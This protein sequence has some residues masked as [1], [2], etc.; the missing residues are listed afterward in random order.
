[1]SPI[2]TEEPE[3]KTPPTAPEIPVELWPQS[4]KESCLATV[5]DSLVVQP[6]NAI[7]QPVRPPSSIDSEHDS[8]QDDDEQRYDEEENLSEWGIMCQRD[9]RPTPQGESSNRELGYMGEQNDLVIS[10]RTEETRYDQIMTGWDP[11]PPLAGTKRSRSPEQEII[12]S[13]RGRP[14]KKVDYKKLHHGKTVKIN[15]DPK[16]WTEAMEGSEAK[17]WHVAAQEEFNSLKETGAIKI[18]D[19]TELP[20]GR[21]LMKSKWVFKKK[22]Q[23]DG[24]LDKY[25]AR[26]TVKGYTQRPGI[27]YKETFAPTPRPETGRI[28]LAL[29]HKLNWYR[30]QG[31]VPV[32]FLNPDLDIDLYMELPEGFK[33]TNKIILIKK[34]LYG[35]KQAAAL[36]YDNMRGFLETQGMFPTE[37]D[38]CLYANK[39]KDVFIIIHVDDIQVIG[40]NLAKVEKLMHALNRKYKLKTV[41]TDMFLGIHISNPDKTTLKLSQGQYARKL[42]ER[43]GM[44]N[45]KTA[46]SPIEHLMEPSSSESSVQLKLEYNSIIGG[47]QYLANNSRPDISFAVNHLARFLTNPSE[48]HLGAARRVLRFI[49]NDPDKGIT[50]LKGQGKPKLEA[51]SDADFAG[52]PSTSRSTSGS[53]IRLSS[54][55]ICWRSHLQRDVVLSTTEA[56][57]LA[58]TETCRQLDWVKI[59]LESTD[60]QNKIEGSVCTNLYIDNQSAISLVK[61]HDNHK[62]SRHI[63]LRNHYC[64]Q[65]YRRGFISPIYV[66]SNRQLADGLTKVK[67]TVQ[68]L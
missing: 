6:T 8:C 68:L 66:E 58:A 18:I 30:R 5:E 64:R 38:V 15:A 48:E 60:L 57:Y 36:W 21:T 46:K 16:T 13:K 14:V 37:A 27:D 17:Q 45:C 33:S 41:K 39:S 63:A 67:S 24:T 11:V 10:D 56:E 4:S 44:A 28:M 1:M 43:H 34:G 19:H 49:A 23:S 59:L 54:G 47:L 55:P 26:C 29:S 42:L 12:L 31:D 62:R 7:N 61:N 51:Y 9:H 53:L 40:P 50:F 3:N 65:Q 2:L 25:R 52:D 32:A 20:K 22:Y 35:L